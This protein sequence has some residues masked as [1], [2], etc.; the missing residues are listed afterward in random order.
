[1]RC[2][3]P[4]YFKHGK[5]GIEN[6]L[7]GGFEA[8]GHVVMSQRGVFVPIVFPYEFGQMVGRHRDKI[9]LRGTSFVLF[10]PG[11][12]GLTHRIQFYSHVDDFSSSPPLLRIK[13]HEK[14]TSSRF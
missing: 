7:N 13:E 4:S 9:L 1:M 6:D 14:I 2:S 3:N 5:L 10:L 8:G 12:V 11:G